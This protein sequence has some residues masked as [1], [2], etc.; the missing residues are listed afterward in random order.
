LRNSTK[1]DRRLLFAVS[2]SCILDMLWSKS[3]WLRGPCPPK[4]R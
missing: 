1:D 3:R 2:G 4:W